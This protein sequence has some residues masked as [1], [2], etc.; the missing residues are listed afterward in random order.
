MTRHS[1]KNK[2]NTVDRAQQGVAKYTKKYGFLHRFY[3]CDECSYYHIT[4]VRH[5][6]GTKVLSLDA[7]QARAKEK[8]SRGT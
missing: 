8:R 6:D 1:A 5:E 7:L 3:L 4:T 2:Y